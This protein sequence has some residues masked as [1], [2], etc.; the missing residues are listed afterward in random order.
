M[1]NRDSS[2]KRGTTPRLAATADEPPAA[3]APAKP[4]TRRKAGAPGPAAKAE[5]KPR[6]KKAPA[7]AVQ[8]TPPAKAAPKKRVRKP[9]VAAAG[10]APVDPQHRLALIARAAYFRAEKRGFQPGGET[11]DWIEAEAEVDLL[12]RIPRR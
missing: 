9:A 1:A 11:Q 10:K 7:K 2:R 6:A 12:L 8:N 3:A 4:A 5:A